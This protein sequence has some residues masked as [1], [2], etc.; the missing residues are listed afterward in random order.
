MTSNNIDSLILVLD[1]DGN[2]VSAS[3]TGG[4]S[5]SYMSPSSLAV[6][7]SGNYYQAGSISWGSSSPKTLDG[8][9]CSAND[10][11]FVRK[12]NSSHT[13]QWTQLY[14]WATTQNKG[15]SI[16]L[17][18][19]EDRLYWVATTSEDGPINGKTNPLEPTTAVTI[20]VNSL[21]TS[22][23]SFDMT[24]WLPYHAFLAGQYG[25]GA[26]AIDA[27]DNLYIL[28]YQAN[29]KPEYYGGQGETQIT[30]LNSS[31]VEQWTRVTG[32]QTPFMGQKMESAYDIHSTS[33]GQL[34]IVG[35]SNGYNGQFHGDSTSTSGAFLFKADGSHSYIG[36]DSFTIT[37]TGTQPTST[38][39]LTLTSSDTGE[40]I[41]LSDQ[42]T[43]TIPANSNWNNALS[44]YVSAVQDNSS[45][46]N[47]TPNLVITTSSSD[48]AWNGLTFNVPVT[49]VNQTQP[50]PYLT[51]GFDN[52]TITEGNSGS[53][54][55]SITAALDRVATSTVTVNLSLNTSGTCT[56]D[57]SDYSVSSPITINSG[58]SQATSNVT[59]YG[60]TTVEDNE[61]A[62]ID[63]ASVTNATEDGNQQARLNILNN[64]IARTVNLS[65]SPTSVTEGDSGNQ[66]VSI[67]AT[68]SA[69]STEAT[70]VTIS[71]TTV[72]AD[73]SS[74]TGTPNFDKDHGFG[75][76]IT[77]PAGSLTGSANVYIYGDEVDEDDETFYINLTNI[78][79]GEGA[80]KGSTDTANITIIDDD[81]AAYRFQHSGTVGDN[82]TV[83]ESGTIGS[84]ENT[85]VMTVRLLT[86]P[87]TGVVV[88]SAE[89]TDT[90]EFTVSPDN[91]TFDTDNWSTNQEFTVTGVPDG[92]EDGLQSANL[93]LNVVD[94]ATAD[95]KWHSLPEKNKEVDVYNVF[96]PS[97]PTLNSATAGV[98]QIT[99]AW[100]AYSGATGYKL[101]YDTNS[102]VSTSDSYISI[103]NTST[104][105]IHS[106]RV[107]GTTYYYRLIA[108]TSGG[109]TPL[110]NELST[111]ANAFDGCNSSG[112]KTDNDPDLL[113]H[114]PFDGNF[115]DVKDTNGDSRYDMSNVNG[116]MQFVQGCA[117][118]QALYIDATSGQLVNDQF[119]D[120]NVGG[121]L[122]F[123]QL[124]SQL[125]GSA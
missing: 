78:T 1:T 120:A 53:Q 39:T 77:I 125:L 10:C 103:D 98:G 67:T 40:M 121:N 29:P 122:G 56:A 13:L 111:A 25:G 41:P 49:V 7:S 32:G 4:S 57:N 124:Y 96:A 83:T 34:Y 70:T 14:P 45:D 89:S 71:G 21:L 27:S 42:G 36:Q 43:K 104:S 81:T 46:S 48:A 95:P 38:V 9:T 82:T 100:T 33:G 84:I 58:Q 87:A 17:N 11:L 92:I 52:G 30:K 86:R 108:T 61:T 62:C 66:A 107:A 93:K 31:G 69:T 5:G 18:A 117:Q 94:S 26:L 88:I 80:I 115:E 75:G 73:A 51:L 116:T 99:I 91:L 85:D 102:S 79:G 72:P 68:I 110:S 35:S 23:G 109:D 59:V 12:F 15:G 76:A 6:D 3:Q 28:Y 112:V 74:G 16:Q 19:A 37:A 90:G 44:I 113:V 105:Y 22:D 8:Q 106:G 47:T 114:Y 119:T 55:K 50:G 24:Q 63:V 101:Y 118:G 60:D 20:I 54:T 2:E 97:P 64:D 65:R 123:W